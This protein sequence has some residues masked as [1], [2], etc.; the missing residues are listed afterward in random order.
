MAF[1]LT[2]SAVKDFEKESTCPARWRAQWLDKLISFQE[3]D[4]MKKGN[5]FEWL[6]LGANAQQKDPPSP[7]LLKNGNKST[8]TL[9]IEEQASRVK[10]LL[11]DPA[12][13]DWLR[14]TPIQAQLF[15]PGGKA[16]R[17]GT[18]DLLAFDAAAKDYWIVD[19][20][21]TGDLTS[22]RT[23]YSWGNDWAEMDNLQLI[24]YRTLAEHHFKVPFRTGLLVADYSPRKRIEFGEIN[25][26][27][28]A[29]AEY[30]QRFSY[31]EQGI[32][33]YN[34]KGWPR[35][36]EKNNCGICTLNCEKR[37]KL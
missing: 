23:P 35:I 11:F 10:A 2:Q 14:L 13:P 17:G 26:T 33:H 6:I 12:H 20:K 27:E 29:V 21:L 18:I 34:T 9:R 8:D 31:V 32:E 19:L 1:I 15:L 24:H 28:D 7:I 30:E 16:T 37:L 36:P 22:K 3:T 5:Y 25:F 4:H